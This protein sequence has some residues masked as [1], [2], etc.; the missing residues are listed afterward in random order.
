MF[1]LLS[2]CLTVSAFAPAAV[3]SRSSTVALLAQNDSSDFMRWARASRSAQ[4]GD[5]VVELN[6]PLGVVLNEDEY[7]NVYV[8]AVAPRGN[9]ARTGKVC[10]EYNARVNVQRM[11]EKKQRG[12]SAESRWC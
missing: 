2:T 1:L 6:R 8:E 7:G 11:D 9:A 5:T 4:A 3:S 12:W 10:K